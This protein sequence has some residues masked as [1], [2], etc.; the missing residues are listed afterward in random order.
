MAAPALESART[1]AAVDQRAAADGAVGGAVGGAS[2]A[3]EM[4]AVAVAA[5]AA[6]IESKLG[7]PQWR[8][9]LSCIT[10]P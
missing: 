8:A 9:E 5:A 1:V 3:V 10:M 2:A 6:A 4:V 7:V